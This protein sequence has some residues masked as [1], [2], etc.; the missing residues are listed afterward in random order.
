MTNPLPSS[1]KNCAKPLRPSREHLR[2]HIK[3]S[4]DLD[5]LRPEALE[6][7]NMVSREYL[8]RFSALPMRFGDGA[9]GTLRL[10]S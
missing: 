4:L 3:G 1:W 2:L 6:R 10:T 5:S 8:T 9:T 7:G